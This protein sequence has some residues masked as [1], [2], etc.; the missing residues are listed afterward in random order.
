MIHMIETIRQQWTHLD[1]VIQERTGA[2]I[3][4]LKLLH[5]AFHPSKACVAVDLKRDGEF[6]YF[7]NVRI[8]T[9]EEWHQIY[10]AVSDEFAPWLPAVRLKG[11]LNRVECRPR[12][13]WT[14][15][16]VNLITKY[17]RITRDYWIE[18]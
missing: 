9:L 1:G 18:Q 6:D 4:Y 10:G 11:R 2:G 3:K 12:N 5:P 15:I 8:K 17:L 7:A 14:P 13:F 16:N